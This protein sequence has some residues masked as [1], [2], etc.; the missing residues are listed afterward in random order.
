MKKYFFSISFY[1]WSIFLLFML[2]YAIST[3]GI[4]NSVDAPQYALTKSLLINRS[5][6]IDNY[7]QY[8]TPD[9]ALYKNHYYSIRSPF[10]SIFAIPFYLIATPLSRLTAPPYDIHH[11]GI[12]SESTIESLTTIYNAFFGALTIT[13]LFLFCFLLTKDIFASFFSATAFGLGTLFWKYSSTFQRHS[14]LMFFFLLFFYLL[15]KNLHMNNKFYTFLIGLSCGLCIALDNVYFALL[16]IVIFIFIK[17]YFNKS[18]LKT[19]KNI[20]FFNLGFLPPIITIMVF[21]FLS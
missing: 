3:V 11:L 19:I 6:S 4:M 20:I 21:N 12:T 14:A 5:I 15:H 10:E 2:L 16:P 8:I 9:Y 13:L 1:A 18:L 17:D 7:T